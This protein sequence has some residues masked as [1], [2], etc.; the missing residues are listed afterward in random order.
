M[1]SL[2]PA[3]NA[4]STAACLTSSKVTG[5]SAKLGIPSVAYIQQGNKIQV[6]EGVSTRQ[7]VK[8]KVCSPLRAG[9]GSPARGVRP[10]LALTGVP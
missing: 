5:T 3:A 2:D 6:R 9:K 4:D 1:K 8:T 10:E 7:S